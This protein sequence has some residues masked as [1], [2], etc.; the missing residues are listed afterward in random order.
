MANSFRI[1]SMDEGTPGLAFAIDR[2]SK[3]QSLAYLTGHFRRLGDGF[4]SRPKTY[5]EQGNKIAMFG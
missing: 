1:A 5:V 4:T 3:A 2:S